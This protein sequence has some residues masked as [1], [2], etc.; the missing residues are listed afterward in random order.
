MRSR[1]GGR[2]EG[3]R[4]SDAVD[5]QQVGEGGVGKG[6]MTRGAGRIKL[7]LFVTCILIVWRRLL[8]ACQDSLK[9]LLSRSPCPLALLMHTSCLPAQVAVFLLDDS[10]IISIFQHNGQAVTRCEQVGGERFN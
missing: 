8:A 5:L 9:S 4:G 3:D 2:G 7:S 6:K 1:V 10:T